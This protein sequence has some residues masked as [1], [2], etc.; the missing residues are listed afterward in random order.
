MTKLSDRDWDMMV[1]DLKDPPEPNYRLRNLL[2]TS[3]LR[4]Q[5]QRS[6]V[7]VMSK[8]TAV[9]ALDLEGTLISNAVSQIPRPH[10]FEFLEFC[11]ASFSRVVIFTTVPE[12]RFRGI[13]SLLVSEG[14][15][16]SWF[17]DA[18]Y[19]NW[20][21]ATKDLGFIPDCDIN[22]CLLIDDHAPYVHTGQEDRWIEVEQFSHPYNDSDRELEKLLRI[23]RVYFDATETLGSAE[24]AAI[25]LK[26]ENKALGGNTPLELLD[27]EL[28][29]L[30]ITDVLGRIRE[31]IF[32]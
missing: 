32:S 5:A 17:K 23:I 11:K 24:K 2:A 12:S 29:M 18:E 4:K 15:V 27:T 7:Y 10:L 30:E 3:S 21:G 19:I 16:P 22:D 14:K 26:R 25:W 9:I 8:N 13:A 20:N 28:G 31:G 6:R 1:A